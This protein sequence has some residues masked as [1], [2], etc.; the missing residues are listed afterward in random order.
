MNLSEQ[1]PNAIAGWVRYSQYEIKTFGN[2]MR[3]TP[4]PHAK[5]ELYDPLAGAGKMLAAALNI[6]RLRR[7]DLKE[8][9]SDLLAFVQRY[10]LLGLAADL[11]LQPDFLSAREILLQ[12]NSFTGLTPAMP[13]AQ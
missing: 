9:E 10:G 11:A 2:G 8:A 6:G 13:S 4:A 1:F 7:H 3:V 12:E 5:A